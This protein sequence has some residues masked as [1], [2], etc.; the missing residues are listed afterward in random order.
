MVS[1]KKLITP[2]GKSPKDIKEWLGLITDAIKGIKGSENWYDDVTLLTSDS[3][4][5]DLETGGVNKAL[6]SEQGKIIN[7]RV[8]E[9][10][11]QLH[12]INEKITRK[13]NYSIKGINLYYR[14]KSDRT[15]FIEDLN[16]AIECGMNTIFIPVYGIWNSST[17]EISHEISDE[18]LSY[19]ITECQ[20]R[21]LRPYLK[22]HKTGDDLDEIDYISYLE[23]W[24]SFIDKYIEFSKTYIIDTLYFINEMNMLTSREDLKS[25]FKSIITKVQNNSLKCG[26]TY[27]GTSE[28]NTSIISEYVDVIGINYYPKITTGGYDITH[29]SAC[30]IIYDK[31]FPTINL[32][33]K[34]YKKDIIISEYGCTRNVDALKDP[35]AWTF[36]TEDQSFEPQKIMYKAGL[37]IFNYKELNILGVIFWSTDNRTKLNSF[38]PFGNTECEEIIKS[39]EVI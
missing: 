14:A 1:W 5:N 26:I 21:N 25:K 3:I 27:R 12:E 36:D 15:R 29:E 37:E 39:Y 4:V 6:S 10:S 11:S 19:L 17:K 34:F 22:C 2:P 20:I 35:S 18:E 9:V 33:N 24:D 7:D 8:N 32:I 31:L 38:S 30:K 28:V 13:M 23:S 16:T